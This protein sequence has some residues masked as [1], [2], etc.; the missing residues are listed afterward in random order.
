MSVNQAYYRMVARIFEIAAQ[1]RDEQVS[2]FPPYARKQTLHYVQWALWKILREVHRRARKQARAFPRVSRAE[3]R[4]WADVGYF[5]L[6]D[7]RSKIIDTQGAP[8]DWWRV[9]VDTSRKIADPLLKAG[10]TPRQIMDISLAIAA[11]WHRQPVCSK[12]DWSNPWT[13]AQQEL[14]EMARAVVDSI[15]TGFANGTI[16]GS[17]RGFEHPGRDDAFGWADS[18]VA[19]FLV[20]DPQRDPEYMRDPNNMKYRLYWTIK[21][22]DPPKGRPN[23]GLASLAEYLRHAIQGQWGLL[24][25]VK[26]NSFIHGLLFHWFMKGESDLMDRPQPVVFNLCG[27]CGHKWEYDG[28]QACPACQEHMTGCYTSKDL[29]VL[30][31]QYGRRPFRRCWTT[32]IPSC[33]SH[34]PKNAAV[35]I[36]EATGHT[37]VCSQGARIANGTSN[38]FVRMAFA[39]PDGDA[40]AMPHNPPI[41]GPG[42]SDDDVT[43]NRGVGSL[44]GDTTLDMAGVEF[45]DIDKMDLENALGKLPKDQRAIITWHCI[46]GMSLGE[47]AKK[48]GCSVRFVQD[49][50]KEAKQKL[51][52]A[53]GDDYADDN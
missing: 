9:L 48:M 50:C 53:L 13:Y 40:G 22:W 15:C 24:T 10:P 41:G 37:P 7:P 46:Q 44:D 19:L 31:D 43:N 47:I 6:P 32:C 42:D 36:D 25:C 20:Y 11:G 45:K 1:V 21:N 23:N 14:T 12:K 5:A 33:P 17:P 16:F 8:A 26:P 34:L 52:K 35:Y 49:Q 18:A 38:L 3:L 30:K 51:R 2:P 39:L 28:S 29:L 27:R 4:F